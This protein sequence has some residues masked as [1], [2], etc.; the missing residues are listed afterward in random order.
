[1]FI[2]VVLPAPFSPSRPR[3]SPDSTVRST[4]SLA[5]TPGNRLVMPL[6]SSRSSASGPSRRWSLTVAH[7]GHRAKGLSSPES[8]DGSRKTEVGRRKTEVAPARLRRYRIPRQQTPPAVGLRG[9]SRHDQL[10]APV[11]RR[12]PT[13]GRR[14]T[15][16]RGGL[17]G[18]A[19]ARAKL[20]RATQR[21]QTPTAHRP[22][23]QTHATRLPPQYADRRGYG[24][25]S[26]HPSEAREIN[27]AEAD[28]NR[29]P[30]RP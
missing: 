29:S 4:E 28:T 23:A 11:L 1:M 6:S 25:S 18:P 3:I 13:N 19:P 22:G 16:T 2:R 15:P 26:P 20:G 24:G 27:T 5:M 7:D 12:T 21:K 30:P 9:G 17:A 14:S 8:E 10:T